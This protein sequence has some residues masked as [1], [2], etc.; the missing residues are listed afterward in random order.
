[1]FPITA[2]LATFLTGQASDL[3]SPDRQISIAQA[4]G[5]HETPTRGEEDG[6]SNSLPAP[7]VLDLAIQL[8][9]EYLGEIVASIRGDTAAVR[10]EDLIPLLEGQIDAVSLETIANLDTSENGFVALDR[11]TENGLRIEFR[12]DSLILEVLPD[13]A[14][15]S[16]RQLS[17]RPRSRID[18]SSA[19]QPATF[20]IGTTTIARLAHIHSQ[21]GLN[22]EF[23]P[24]TAESFGFANVGGFDGWT[25]VWAVDFDERR[26]RRFRRRDV[27]VIKDNFETATRLTIGDFRT[28]PLS[29]FQRSIDMVGIGYRRA[30]TAIQPF[31][32]LL[33]RG[34]SFFTL[35]RHARVR[36]EV[37]GL[38]AF[39]QDLPP[40]SYDLR[41]FPFA[42]GSNSAIITVDDGAGVREIATLSTFVDSSLLAEGIDRFDLGLGFIGNGF[43]AS[44]R[45][46]NDPALV[47]SYD[48]G[49]SGNLTLGAY[50]EIS[51]DLAQVG[52]RSALGTPVGLFSAEVAASRSQ[53]GW[54]A[55]AAA[56]F[57]TQF[58]TGNWRHNV[59]AQA[60]WRSDHYST[61]AAPLDREIAVDLRWIAQRNTLLFSFDASHRETRFDTTDS[62]SLG[63]G[64]RMLDLNWRA[65]GQY[66]GRRG[67]KD[68]QR[69]VLSV[70]IPLGRNTRLRA[71]AGSEGDARLEFQRYGGFAVGESQIYGQL[72]RDSDGYF[73]GSARV[74]HIAN[75][76]EFE[77]D[78]QSRETPTGFFSRSEATV[79]FGVGYAD[80]AIQFGR[81]FDAGF[82]VVDRHR[83]IADKKATLAE[84]GLGIAAH[85]DVFGAPFVPLRS[86]YARYGYTVDVDDLEPDYDLGLDQIEVVPPF[87]AGYR[88]E[89]GSDILTTV[90]ARLLGPDGEPVRLSTGRV[91]RLSDGEQVARFFTNRTGRLVVENLAPGEYRV[92]ADELDGVAAT[93]TVKEGESGFIDHGKLLLG[94]TP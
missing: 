91:F 7:I 56:Q 83:N 2:M 29:S 17:L 21:P 33:P 25:L 84:G 49:I 6:A 52:V 74:R 1:M 31:R 62:V 10:P 27:A 78:H 14:Q 67:R 55:S 60:L 23:E 40:G 22:S 89:I 3:R 57:R 15:R 13:L 54:G 8:D 85:S 18:P 58:E 61:L 36:V 64:W 34:R 93:I 11:L 87:R 71:R 35:E 38:T 76:A 16:V 48:R 92:V 47:A 4:V 90:M 26:R 80:G 73:G 75:R 70:S 43:S 63:V 32:A 20:S 28:R 65:R 53:R 51:F 39:D 5:A 81:P 30:Y 45:Y 77:L 94:D 88:I 66:V 9:Q 86:G 69:A 79:A 44:R 82:I 42:T 68:D 12:S 24:F 37:D 41:D 50:G 59:T 46:E 72:N 19:I